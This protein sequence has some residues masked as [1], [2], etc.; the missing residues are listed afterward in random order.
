MSNHDGSYMLNDILIL[1]EEYKFFTTLTK[2]EISKFCQK[3][4]SIGG[5][6]DCNNGEIFDGIGE[7]LKICYW[8]FNSAE[9]MVDGICKECKK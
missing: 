1:L 4:K 7:R 6:H 9:E 8:C 2:K 5:E 3:V